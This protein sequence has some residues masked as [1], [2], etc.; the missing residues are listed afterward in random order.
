MHFADVEMKL[1]I[2]KLVTAKF[3]ASYSM[4][5]KKL[6]LLLFT[7]CSCACYACSKI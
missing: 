1:R 4:Y 2:L 3:N 6:Q 7:D 5:I